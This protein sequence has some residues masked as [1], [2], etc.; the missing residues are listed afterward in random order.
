MEIKKV[1][2]FPVQKSIL[3]CEA[4]RES[5]LSLYR[6]EQK[7]TCRFFNH[8]VNDTYRI[9]GEYDNYYL[10][11]YR[12]NWR[13]KEDIISEIKLL[14]FL[15]NCEQISVSAPIMKIDG[16][17]L[18]EI[19]A[20]EGLRY[21]VL[22]R[23]AIG[24][25]KTLDP[26]RSFNYGKTAAII[27]TVAD[28]LESLERFHIDL[29]HLLDEPLKHIKPFL[30][31]REEDYKYLET[32]ARELS[33]KVNKLLSKDKS[34]Y[35]LCHG[36][37]HN[38][39]TFLDND[40]NLT[41]FDFDCFGYGWRA[42]DISVFLWSCGSSKNWRKK[43]KNYRACLWNS[44]LKGYNEIKKLTKEELEAAFLFV[45]IRHIWILGLH[46]HGY[47]DWGGN[48]FNEDYFNRALTFIKKWIEH[49]EVL[50]QSK[51]QFK[52]RIVEKGLIKPFSKLI[53]HLGNQFITIK[54]K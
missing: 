48:R 2:L 18:T 23:S 47:N 54:N 11:I 3:S 20:P 22:F 26:K 30:S 50:P 6:I 19:N 32:T 37:F 40:D 12:Y 10:R 31:K 25:H 51:N 5:I 8:G 27:H 29:E 44:Y 17:F 33:S 4:I 16:E 15:K 28:E 34:V 49:Y 36:D 41:V 38:G 53:N 46:T 21:A 35:G 39:N 24:E 1:S 7:Y 42:Y 45:P 9:E 13:R 43:D 52:F 14:N